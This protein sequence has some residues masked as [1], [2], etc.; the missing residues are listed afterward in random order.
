MIET[1]PCPECRRPAQVL[2]RFA[3]NDAA[4]AVLYLRVR[5]GGPIAFLVAARETPADPGP[6]RLPAA[7]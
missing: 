1:V 6:A 5:C 7:A 4:G 3:V 2:S